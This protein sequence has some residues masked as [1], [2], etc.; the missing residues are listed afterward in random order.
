[1]I[2]NLI[3]CASPHGMILTKA[4]CEK[5]LDSHCSY[6]M[7]LKCHYGK[8]TGCP[9]FWDWSLCNCGD[10]LWS[11]SQPAFNGL[12]HPGWDGKNSAV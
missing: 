1:M 12:Y 11:Q 4:I 5:R 10:A 8:K 6:F 9:N 3:N 7:D 2:L